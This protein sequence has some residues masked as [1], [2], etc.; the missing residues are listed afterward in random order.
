MVAGPKDDDVIMESEE[1][2]VI[3]GISDECVCAR[4][5]EKRESGEKY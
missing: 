3:S 1:V 2:G 5:R 4:E